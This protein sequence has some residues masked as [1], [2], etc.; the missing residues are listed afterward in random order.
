MRTRQR[1][2]PWRIL[3]GTYEGNEEERV[4]KAAQILTE[5]PLYIEE[6]PDFSLKD[7]EDRIKKNIRDN[8]V[9]YVFN[10]NRVL[11]Q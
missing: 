9:K 1:E 6:L 5:S 3:N 7:I 4:R 8:N 11:G 2:Q 10:S